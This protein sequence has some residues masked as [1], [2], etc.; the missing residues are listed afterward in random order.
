M[1]PAAV[2]LVGATKRAF[3][4]LVEGPGAQSHP[5]L[6]ILTVEAKIYGL[7]AVVS[8]TIPVVQ[9]RNWGRKSANQTTFRLRCARRSRNSID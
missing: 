5:G 9:S 8:E 2:E 6:E 1:V 7:E 3:Q 4:Q